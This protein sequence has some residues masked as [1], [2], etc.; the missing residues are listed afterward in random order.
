MES[1]GGEG[2]PCSGYLTVCLM[3]G[4]TYTI[5]IHNMYNCIRGIL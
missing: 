3:Y 2:C 4:T 5:I 1:G